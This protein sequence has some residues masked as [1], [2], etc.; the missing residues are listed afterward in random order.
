MFTEAFAFILVR[1]FLTRDF[2][3]KM[4]QST[5]VSLEPMIFTKR[6]IPVFLKT[7]TLR[8]SRLEDNRLVLHEKNLNERVAFDFY[9]T[10]SLVCTNVILKTPFATTISH[11]QFQRQCVFSPEEARLQNEKLLTLKAQMNTLLG[12]GFVRVLTKRYHGAM[13]QG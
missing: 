1:T 3:G 10:D 12:E 9:A 13:K 7:S 2:T 11:L 5:F 6:R 8:L 4:N